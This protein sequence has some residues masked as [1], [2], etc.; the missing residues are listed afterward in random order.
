[1]PLLPLAIAGLC[2]ALYLMGL[3]WM[4]E[5]RRHVYA[6]AGLIA[7]ALLAIGIAGCGGGS[8]GGGGGGST[9]TINAAYGGDTNYSSSS[10]SAMVT[11]Q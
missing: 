9:R 5:K 6:Y 2:A 10:G 7:F 1:M 4:P 3:R 8:G 11:I